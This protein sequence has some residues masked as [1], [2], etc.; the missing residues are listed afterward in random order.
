MK[1]E[2]L[3]FTAIAKRAGNRWQDLPPKEKEPY[4]SE[5]TSGK[6]KYHGEMSEYKTTTSYREHQQYLTEFKA[7][8]A[9]NT[10]K[11]RLFVPRTL[12]DTKALADGKRPKLAKRDS[13]NSIESAI[14]Q[15]DASPSLSCNSELRH[16]RLDSIGSGDHHSTT[17]GFSSPAKP[18]YGPTILRGGISSIIPLGNASPN[19]ISP[20]T[21]SMRRD[22]STGPIALGCDTRPSIETRSERM[23]PGLG[24]Q[25]RKEVSQQQSLPSTT[26]GSN[27]DPRL[28]QGRMSPAGRSRRSTRIPSSIHH[29]TSDTSS[30]SSIGSSLSAPSTTPSSHQYS[31]GSLDDGT[32]AA[33]SLPPLSSVGPISITGPLYT[34]PIARPIFET[35]AGRNVPSYSP[36]QNSPSPLYHSSTTGKFESLQLPLPHNISFGQRPLPRPTNE[37]K[38]ANIFDLQDIPRE[39]NS[40]RNLSLEQAQGSATPPSRQVLPK[41][42]HSPHH[43]ALPTLPPMTSRDHDTYDPP[44]L[45]YN[46]DP[47]SVCAY[48]GRLVGRET[49]R[50]PS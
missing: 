4:E 7:K 15:P 8:N 6:E 41:P 49:H 25:A 26:L 23:A 47:L 9:S 46:A 14:S 30:K 1:S 34:D 3:S 37:E 10:G 16:V 45:H 11:L 29:D 27:I 20:S 42:Q 18:S 32:K 44:V 40:L 21:P 39:R 31:P 22:S 24:H 43:P 33:L 38:L 50:P 35:L 48:A 13:T 17:S 36:S 2:S 5:A 12:A 19:P 28:Q